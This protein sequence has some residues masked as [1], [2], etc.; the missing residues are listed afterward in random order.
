MG[1]RLLA[2][3][4][5]FCDSAELV[6]GDAGVWKRADTRET[7]ALRLPLCRPILPVAV[8]P[9]DLE[10]ARSACGEA[11]SWSGMVIPEPSEASE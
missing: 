6:V 8:R 11:G 3:R 5:N 9:R 4:L 2:R 1:L 7:V 10:R